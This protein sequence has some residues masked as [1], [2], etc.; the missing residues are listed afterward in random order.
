METGERTKSR[1]PV[2]APSHL[3][4]RPR[5]IE[6]IDGSGA[7][8]VVLHAPAG[9]GKTTVA[10]QWAQRR[11]RQPIWYRCTSASA[12]VAVLATGVAGALSELARG[13]GPEMLKSLR[14][15]SNPS[16]DVERFVELL[17]PRLADWPSDAWFVIDDYHYVAMSEA[18]EAVIEGVALDSPIQL[19]VISRVRPAWASTRRVLY[20]EVLDVDHHALSFT[21]AESARVLGDHAGPFGELAQGWPAIVG[22][23]ARLDGFS[24][25]PSGL[26]E[27]L[28]EFLADE[29]YQGSPAAV[30]DASLRL[31]VCPTLDRRSIE[32]VLGTEDWSDALELCVRL[33]F[34]QRDRDGGFELHPLLRSF[35]IEKIRRSGGDDLEGHVP[36][37]LGHDLLQQGRWAEV[38]SLHVRFPRAEL[39]LELLEA[40]VDDLIENGRLETID[41][42][43]EHAATEGVRHP[44][45]DLAGAKLALRRG[46]HSRAEILATTAAE[47]LEP[48]HPALANALVTAGQAALLGD[49]SNAARD[50]FKRAQATASSRRD[51]REALLGDFFAAMELEHQDAPDLLAEL[52]ESDHPDA[53]TTL[54]LASARLIVSAFGG[55]IA[56]ALDDAAPYIH[57][58]ESVDDAYAKSSFL[59]T[60]ASMS[61]L[62]ARYGEALQF[63]HRALG[64]ARELGVSFAVPH[65]QT[66]LAMAEMG[67]RRFSRAARTF[68]EVENRARSF[69]DAFLEG[70]AR[71]FRARLLLMRGKSA[72]ALELLPAEPASFHH[73]GL[74]AEHHTMR[75][76]ILATQG[77]LAEALREGDAL[78]SRR[79]ESR[80]LRSWSRAVVHL[81]DP[82][83][84]PDTPHDAFS[85][86]SATGTF[87]TFVCAYRA[88]PQLLTDLSLDVSLQP[89]LAGVLSRANDAALA[90]R[91]GLTVTEPTPGSEALS[92]RELEV[93]R[94]LHEGLSNREIAQSLYISLAT[95]KVHL[96]HIYGKLG[97]RNRAQAI[98]RAPDL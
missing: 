29:L 33:D 79:P 86:A 93:L 75:A 57:L 35:L 65:A 47:A 27:E 41:R 85:L 23:A 60:L 73:P 38:F 18:A 90:R 25:P 94:L 77:A 81:Q 48:A 3:I 20:G 96:H 50:L 31:A 1:G 34:L 68:R 80:T 5:L 70:N 45:V 42:W 98:V 19:L 36:R 69:D 37:K 58:L 83:L 62:T 21:R 52:E 71:G 82:S 16:G 10:R 78:E 32:V 2:A 4:E 88:Y 89:T 55:N 22:L 97:V 13:A 49:D 53:Q 40:S 72:E 12:D 56:T 95:V 59:N 63:A 64:L 14:A 84:V 91:V 46:E 61:N 67:L 30:Q 44:L 39:F 15:S 17:V 26:P 24:P 54:R 11:T 51:R 92:P 66:N 74:R 43:L 87:D 6:R 9:Y 7:R 28:F 8:I 76:L